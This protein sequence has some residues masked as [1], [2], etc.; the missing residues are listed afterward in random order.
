M[1]SMSEQEARLIYAHEVSL[2]NVFGGNV[3]QNCL[4]RGVPEEIVEMLIAETE[5][6]DRSLSKFNWDGT[7]KK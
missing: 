4:D 3:R 7:L 2:C 5:A 1:K 6:W